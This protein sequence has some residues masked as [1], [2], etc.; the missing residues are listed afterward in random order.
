MDTKLSYENL[1]LPDSPSNILGEEFWYGEDVAINILASIKDPIKFSATVSI[2]VKQGDCIVD[3]DL[4]EYKIK[5]PCIVQIKA[6]QIIQPKAASEDFKASYIVLSSKLSDSL[7]LSLSS[8]PQLSFINRFQVVKV[9]ENLLD[10][11]NMFYAGLNTILEDKKNPFLYNSLQHYILTFLY[12]KAYKVFLHPDNKSLT[13]PKG[14]ISDRFLLLVQQNFKKERF[15]EF[16]AEKLGITPKHLSRTV[17]LQTGYTGVEWIARFVVLEAK[18]LLKS[19][20]LNI[21]QISDE[22][23]FKSQSFFGKYF[24]KITGMSPKSFRNQ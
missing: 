8:I 21:Q 19:S 7:F 16:Y 13:T 14:R 18:V 3:I 15:L 20:N 5:A 22:L 4:T 10:D 12:A 23:N 9:P 6:N 24:K 2:Y 11:F 17:K 1:N